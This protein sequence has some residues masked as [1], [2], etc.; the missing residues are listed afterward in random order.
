MSLNDSEVEVCDGFLASEEKA[1]PK[2]A[3]DGRDM[4]LLCDRFCTMGDVEF[5]NDCLGVSLWVSRESV[6]GGGG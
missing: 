1:S 4:F 5:S 6:G 3:S 2:E